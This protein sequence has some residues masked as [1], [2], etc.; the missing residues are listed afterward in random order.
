MI[1]S[2]RKPQHQR[3]ADDSVN[4]HST[5]HRFC[6]L[7]LVRCFL[8]ITPFMY[9]TATCHVQA[10]RDKAKK[11]PCWRM[12]LIL[13]LIFV[14]ANADEDSGHLV[15]VPGSLAACVVQYFG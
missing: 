2:A 7:G 9:R 15:R 5:T 4:S 3:I 10:R 14:F 11:V 6:F 1:P 12:L 13:V 8:I